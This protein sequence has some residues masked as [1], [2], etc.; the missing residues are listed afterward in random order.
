[1]ECK[2]GYTWYPSNLVAVLIETYWNVNIP[3]YFDPF[4]ERD[5][6][7]ETYWN[8]NIIERMVTKNGI[9][10]LIETYWNVN[11]YTREI[12]YDNDG[13]INRNILECK[14]VIRWRFWCSDRVLIETYWNVNLGNTQTERVS[15]AVL[16]ETYW[17][18]NAIY[19]LLSIFFYIGI[20][21][22]ILEC[23]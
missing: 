18:V 2:Y 16:I 5:V 9:F 22:N 14:C 3:R 7:I 23:K 10:V 17:N 12:Y 1:M 15:R 6:L 20:N 4:F 8:V 21:R 11:I 19:L 13:C